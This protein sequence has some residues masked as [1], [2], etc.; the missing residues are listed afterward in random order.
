MDSSGQPLVA[1]I[2]PAYNRG[3]YLAA[4]WAACLAQDYEPLEVIAVDDGS[5]DDTGAIMHDY[6][7]R[8]RRLRT[9]SYPVNQGQCVARNVGL[10]L[11]K[12]TLVKFLDSDD[13]LY[14]N[15]IRAQVKLLIEHGADVAVSGFS[16]F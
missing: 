4:T 12:S 11:A 2:V 16:E 10:G 8:D 1:I 6:A 7:T 15:T 9:F 3:S 5:S 13:L 14:T